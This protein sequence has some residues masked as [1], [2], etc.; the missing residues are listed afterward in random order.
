[1]ILIDNGKQRNK[2][3]QARKENKKKE[4]RTLLGALALVEIRRGTVGPARWLLRAERH[5]SNRTL[6]LVGTCKYGSR[7]SEDP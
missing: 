3:S 2:E 5:S 7:P 4:G 1:M 6:V